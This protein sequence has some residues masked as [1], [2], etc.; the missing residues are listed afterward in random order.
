MSKRTTL[1]SAAAITGA[2]LL[3]LGLAACG[4]KPAPAEESAA[5]EATAATA[6][7]T[8]QAMRVTRVEQRDLSDEVVA[9]GRL[10]VREEAAV[11]SELAGYR[12]AAVYVDEGDWV[13][14]GQPMAKLDDA[15]L[16][17]QIAQAE[18]TLATQKATGISRRTSSS[19]LNRWR[20]KAPSPRNCLNSAAQNRPA[21]KPRGWRRRPPS[22]R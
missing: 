3:W 7:G 13:K 9:T 17:A 12:V 21:P 15:L 19:A 6:P 2:G 8:V 4:Q 14:Q 18:A 16:Q 20:R 11:G 22:T 1:A 10:V 5:A